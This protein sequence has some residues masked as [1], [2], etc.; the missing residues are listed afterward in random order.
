MNYMMPLGA[1]VLLH[2]KVTKTFF[3]MFTKCSSILN[4]MVLEDYEVQVYKRDRRLMRKVKDV[5]L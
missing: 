5:G 2:R 4:D 3:Q 1:K